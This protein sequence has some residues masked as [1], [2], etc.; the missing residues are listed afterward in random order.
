MS[1]IS[2]FVINL[3][4]RKDR[5]FEMADQLSRVGWEAQFSAS[6]RP[7]TAAG[8]PSAGARGCFLSHLEMLKRGRTVGGHV[9]IMEDDLNFVSDF[10]SQW[11]AAYDKLQLN[12]W[13]V[14]YPG[15]TI[16]NAPRGISYVKPNTGIMCAHFIMFNESAVDAI[17]QGLETI[18]L[19]PPGHP[20]GGP[21][22]VD[23]AYS[24]I[25][26]QNP[27]LKTFA[28][29]PSLGRQRSSRSDIAALSFYDR[30]RGLRP[31]VSRLRRFKN[32]L[33]GN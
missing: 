25:R 6:E 5:R 26:C 13:S 14:F 17:I 4:D 10:V 3:I 16:E 31:I 29:S 20:L 18:L 23:G 33:Q 12:D 21:M 32:I 30:M 9:L 8:F 19:R 28:Y 24:T 11:S 2:K 7:S 1:R 27:N 15:H 22:H